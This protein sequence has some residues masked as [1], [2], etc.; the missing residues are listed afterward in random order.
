MPWRCWKSKK[1]NMRRPVLYIL[2]FLSVSAFAGSMNAVKQFLSDFTTV[3]GHVTML[4]EYG[5]QY[6][7]V[8]LN[9]SAT[10]EVF[11]NED[12]QHHMFVVMTV[13]APQCS[14]CARVYNILGEYL[15]PLEPT[16]KSIFPL[17]SIDKETGRIT[18]TD[19]DTWEY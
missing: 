14:S 17:A 15:F 7:R 9:D 11:S 3:G 13:C 16:V 12:S 1:N 18:W 4:E 6:V 5:D 19:N 2:L 8:Q 10:L